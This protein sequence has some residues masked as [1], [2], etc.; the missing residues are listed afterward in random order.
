M[1]FCAQIHKQ[2]RMFLML[3]DIRLNVKNGN[4]VI[5]NSLGFLRVTAPH[6]DIKND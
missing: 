3:F 2:T 4:K 1:F 6:V 5:K